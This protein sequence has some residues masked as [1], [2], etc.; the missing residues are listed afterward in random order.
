MKIIGITG[1][2]GAGKD[3]LANRLAEKT[4]ER[5]DYQPIILS[6]ATPL[7]NACCA[8]FGW[9]DIVYTD[10]VLK[11]KIDPFWGISPRRAA[12]MLGTEGFR[13]LFGGDVHIKA[14]EKTILSLPELDKKLI[15]IPDVR[16]E[17][18][19]SFVRNK[20]GMIIHVK[21]AK[22]TN[23][24]QLD[25]TTRAHKSEEGIEERNG[26]TIIRNDKNSGMSSFHQRI[27]QLLTDP[28]FDFKPAY[29]SDL[30]DNDTDHA[31]KWRRVM[32]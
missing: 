24:E 26:D 25:V 15:L 18:E 21:P 9:P 2:I 11:E 16:F 1:K 29:R 5:G 22:D 32:R 4:L 13:E 20:G 19:A 6:F 14:M 23:T 17:N 30:I 28:Y 12:Q 27:D 10:R 7:K 3:T 31:P 8:F